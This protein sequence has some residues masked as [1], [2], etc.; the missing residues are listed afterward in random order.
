[1]EKIMKIVVIA[2]LAAA[3]SQQPRSR[4][5]EVT[6]DRHP[7]VQTDTVLA[8][9]PDESQSAF[10][11]LLKIGVTNHIP[12][13]III[14]AEP[15]ICRTQ[16]AFNSSQQTV[17]DLVAN[18]NANLPGYHAAL[19]DGVLDIVPTVLPDDVTKL[20]NMQLPSFDIASNP[21]NLMGSALWMNIRLILA[22]TEGAVGGGMS[23]PTAEKAPG[24]RVR[25]QTVNSIL[26]R[27]ADAATGGVWILRASMVQNLSSTRQRPYE[28]YGY[29]GQEQHIISDIKCS[30]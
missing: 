5:Y 9:Q 13:G 3:L 24:F 1:L 12:I 22:P 14:G 26:N 21:H 7:P 27:I 19:Q 25:N 16:L 23:S 28:I 8:I 18:I 20:L 11:Q 6:Y 2:L 17:E 29:V 30:D 15:R 10:Q 4:G